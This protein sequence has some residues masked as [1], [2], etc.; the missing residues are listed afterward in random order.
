MRWQAADSFETSRLPVA[1]PK[2]DCICSFNFGRPPT[3]EIT[4]EV[5]SG[6]YARASVYQ[7]LAELSS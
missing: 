4:S 3:V 2:H 1:I 7:L 5:S 6:A